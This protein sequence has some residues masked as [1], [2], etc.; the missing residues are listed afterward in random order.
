MLYA[1]LTMVKQKMK[2]QKQA[3]WWV[4]TACQTPISCSRSLGIVSGI[5]QLRVDQDLDMVSV[6]LLEL[7][8][9]ELPIDG[10]VVLGLEDA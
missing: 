5:H 1:L 8:V 10:R 7:V 4:L 3:I 9:A 2:A 6:M